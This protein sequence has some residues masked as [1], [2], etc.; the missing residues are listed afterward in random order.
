M[1]KNFLRTGLMILG[2]I[3]LVGNV[4]LLLDDYYYSNNTGQ[5]LFIF[6]VSAI[7]LFISKLNS[8]DRKWKRILKIC[9]TLLVLMVVFFSYD[10]EMIDSDNWYWFVLLLGFIVMGIF[11]DRVSSPPFFKNSL[12]RVPIEKPNDPK[13]IV[14]QVSEL[15]QI[16][17]NGSEALIE[18]MWPKVPRKEVFPLEC[19]RV[20]SLITSF[21]LTSLSMAQKNPNFLLKEVYKL[22]RY[23][24]L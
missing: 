13:L 12:S 9:L 2:L 4:F 17:K 16:C 3:L 21:L 15:T 23:Q 1:K 24:I 7:L 20:Q 14:K 5:V 11:T 18:H 22:F 8:N 19:F 6:L 10:E